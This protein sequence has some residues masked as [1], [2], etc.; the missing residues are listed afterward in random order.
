MPSPVIS[1]VIPAHNEAALIGQ[2]IQSVHQAGRALGQPYEIIVAADACTDDTA[3]IA[4]QLGATV[5]PVDNRQIAGTRNDGAA[6]ASAP[7]LFFLDADTQLPA[8]TL[9]AAVNALDAGAVAGGAS[10]KFDHLNDIQGHALIALW[11]VIARIMK[12]AA[13]SC[14]FTRT[15][16]F[17][18]V[19]G[20]DT[21]FYAGEELFLSEKL[22]TKGPFTHLRE[23]VVTSSRKLRTHSVAEMFAVFLRFA[24]TGGAAL[25][26][27][28][29]LDVWYDGKRE[30]PATI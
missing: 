22:N 23:H 5:I 25:Q 15:D 9:R 3:S 20:F 26:Q 28:E 10:V 16:T 17:Q 7:Y 13:G 29:G 14:L 1:I 2:T 12:W 24:Y 4:T 27:R 30:D 18:A 19:G 6:H 21:R 8:P 11:T